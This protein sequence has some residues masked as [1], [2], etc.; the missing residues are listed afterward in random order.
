[1]ISKR[2]ILVSVSV[3]LWKARQYD[4]N[5]AEE[6]NIKYKSQKAGNYIKILIDQ[7]E[8]KEISNIAQRAR[9]FLEEHSLPWDDR[10]WRIIPAEKYNEIVGELK[11]FRDEFNDAVQEFIGKYDVI[12]N[13][14]E[15]ARLK[16]MYDRDE[17]PDATTVE[18]RYAF[19][20]G[21]KPIPEEGDFRVD[22]ENETIQEMEE[23]MLEEQERQKKRAAS[24]IYSRLIKV[25]EKMVDRLSDHNKIIRKSVVQNIVDVCNEIPELNSVIQDDDITEMSREVQKRVGYF[26]TDM[27][28]DD[29]EA[30]ERALT[31]ARKLLKEIKERIMVE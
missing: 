29:L 31:E 7:P 6:V 13:I 10:V 16:D 21:V 15:P 11:E 30:R 1:M 4:R 19:N 17:Y 18:S 12:V 20:I 14:R 24:G 28:K 9:K 5:I 27:L 23:M 25:L 2:A 8:L 3:S 22:V 26:T